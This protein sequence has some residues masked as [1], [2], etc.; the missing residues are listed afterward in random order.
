MGRKAYLT[1]RKRRKNERQTVAKKQNDCPIS[2]HQST[3]QSNNKGNLDNEPS[4]YSDTNECSNVTETSISTVTKNSQ[5]N[6]SSGFSAHLFPA[7][8]QQA[9]PSTPVMPGNQNAAV[10]LQDEPSTVR[11]DSTANNEQSITL[12]MDLENH[13]SVDLEPTCWNFHSHLLE[14][15][16]IDSIGIDMNV[17]TIN[18]SDDPFHDMSAP[19]LSSSGLVFKNTLQEL[20]YSYLNLIQSLDTSEK[21]FMLPSD[22]T[23]KVIRL[24]TYSVNDTSS[25]T[26][27]LTIEINRSHQWLLR[28]FFGVVLRHEHPVLQLLPAYLH[29]G[30]EIKE[31]AD[32][33]DACHYC[34]GIND[35]KFHPLI[36]KHK[37]RF[38]DYTGLFLVMYI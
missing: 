12:N 27:T 19:F 23:D 15:P 34:K 1:V 7:N 22:D 4:A 9:Q 32:T 3:N 29:S 2:D 11:Y 30:D 10:F 38:Y 26:I 5:L 18:H 14:L 16:D 6:S 20:K 28:H 25:P 31:V 37:G 8:I 13:S 33:I 21:W 24:C 36:V 35:Q 17:M